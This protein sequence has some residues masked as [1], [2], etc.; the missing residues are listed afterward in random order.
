MNEGYAARYTPGQTQINNY[1]IVDLLL[2]LRV[3]PKE[4]TMHANVLDVVKYGDP[5]PRVS[6]SYTGI[7]PNESENEVIQG[8]PPTFTTDYYQYAPAGG[9]Y[10]IFV[11]ETSVFADNYS[12]KYNTGSPAKIVVNPVS[13]SVSAASA[14]RSYIPNNRS[15]QVTFGQLAGI[16]RNDDVRLESA[17]VNGEVLEASVGQNKRVYFNVPKLVGAHAGNYELDVTNQNNLFANITKAN[18]TGYVFPST[19]TVEFGNTLA[20]ARFTGASTGELGGYF[21]FEQRNQRLDIGVY[22]DYVVVYQPGDANNYDSV[23]QTVYLEVT[24]A[25]KTFNLSLTGT[26]YVGETLHA[27][28]SGLDAEAATYAVYSWYRVN[29]SG[30]DP[31]LL[32]NDAQY[33]L[34]DADSGYKIMVKVELLSPYDGLRSVESSRTVEQESLTFWQKLAKWFQ[35]I[36]SAIQGLFGLMPG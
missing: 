9:D 30:G 1:K 34:T 5:V 13:L 23:R 28:V 33:N 25:P 32:S 10:S 35:S 16:L 8:G 12:F 3:K 27:V 17:A 31:V 18:P 11:D 14:S 29:P 24:R 6:I 7:S 19:A 2:T 21:Y 4:V 26:L 36:I 15:V 22:P 20:Y